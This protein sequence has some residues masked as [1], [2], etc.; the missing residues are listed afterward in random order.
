M[1]EQGKTFLVTEQQLNELANGIGSQ[2]LW[3][4][5]QP[6]MAIIQQISQQGPPA[7]ED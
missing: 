5:A 3:V 4:K 1:S 7:Q 6:L 2:L